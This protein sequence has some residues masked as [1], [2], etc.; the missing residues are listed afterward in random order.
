MPNESLL[1]EQAREAITLEKVPSG[2]PDRLWGGHGV[3]A[4]CAICRRPVARNQFEIAIEFLRNGPVP[5]LDKH[6]LH[7]GCFMAWELERGLTQARASSDQFHNFLSGLLKGLPPRRGHCLDCLRQM[8]HESVDTI[9]GYLRELGITSRPGP[10]ANCNKVQET[11][12]SD[13]LS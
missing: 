1:R 4:V 5:G 11:F 10:C 3:G 6:H 13:L 7:L 8:Y 9:R 12:R 2:Q